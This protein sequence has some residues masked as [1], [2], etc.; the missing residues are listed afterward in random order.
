M[1]NPNEFRS[2]RVALDTASAPAFREA[3]TRAGYESLD[4]G[5]RI[6]TDAG[7]EAETVILVVVPRDAC[8]TRS[9]RVAA[10]LR[11]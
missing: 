11:P 5:E 4:T 8:M 6:A 2:F 10:L 9:D 1:S 3:L 7:V